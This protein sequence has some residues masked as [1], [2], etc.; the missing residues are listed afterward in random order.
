VKKVLLDEISLYEKEI[1]EGI[2]V[3]MLSWKD[4]TINFIDQLKKFLIKFKTKK[5]IFIKDFTITRT[6]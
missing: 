4:N 6:I 1:K 2:L 3:N 5:N